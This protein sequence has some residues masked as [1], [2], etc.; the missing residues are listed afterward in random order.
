MDTHVCLHVDM[1]SLEGKPC[2]PLPALTR[3][4]VPPSRHLPNPLTP[5]SGRPRALRLAWAL[6][7]SMLVDGC[8]PTNGE[9]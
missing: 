8:Q 3:C 6:M 7:P 1:K 2:A 5:S 9:E 4:L